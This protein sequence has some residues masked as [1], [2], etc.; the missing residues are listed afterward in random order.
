[1]GATLEVAADG[2]RAGPLAAYLPEGKSLDLKDGRIRVGLDAALGAGAAGGKKAR[3]IV[4]GFDYRD[5]PDGEPLASLSA[6]RVLASRIDPAGKVIAIDEVALEGLTARAETTAA[7]GVQALGLTVTPKKTASEASRP[8]PEAAAAPAPAGPATAAPAPAGTAPPAGPAVAAA[9]RKAPS[10]VPLV[11]LDKLHL[12]LASFKFRDLARG[13][14]PVVVSALLENKAR[15]ELLGDEPEGQPPV[16]LLATGSVAPI[17][18]SWSVAMRVAPFAA[19]PSL[20]V[21][22]AAQGI[23]G[24]GITSV[25]PALKEKLDGAELKDGRF[26]AHVEA[27][28]KVSRRGS[29]DI[30]LARGLGLDFLL[31][32]VEFKDGE[33]GPVLA[34]LDE[35]H[36]DLTK[37]DPKS[38]DVHVKAIEIVKP[39]G[40]VSRDKDGLHILGLLIKLPAAEPAVAGAPAPA[41]AAEPA[42]ASQPA[43]AAPA[44]V[45]ADAGKPAA[46]GPEVRIDKFTVTD[47]DFTVKDLVGEPPCI[48][49][50]VGL[51]IDVRG[52]STRALVEDRPVRFNMSVKSGKVPLPSTLKGGALGGALGDAVSVI[53]GTQVTGTKLEERTVFEELSMAGK[54]SVFPIPKGWVKL[55]ANAIDLGAFK[56][57]A[58][59]AG[60][61]LGGGVFDSAVAVRLVGDGSLDTSTR[62]IFTDLELS[63]PPDGPIFRYLH[64]PAPLSTVVFVLRDEN[65]SLKVPLDVALDPANISLA[66]LGAAA[67]ATFVKIVANAIAASPFRVAGTVVDVATLGQAEKA[68]K[69][70]EGDV[71]IDFSPGDAGVTAVQAAKLG[72]LLDRIRDGENIGLKLRHDLG[73]GDISRLGPRANPP[74]KDVE[75]FIE[76]MRRRRLT[77]TAER[78]VAVA[79][80]RAAVAARDPIAADAARER[81]SAADR[82]LGVLEDV[83]DRAHDLLRPGAERQA[84]RRTREACL[85]LAR[86]RLAAVRQALIDSGIKGME[87]RIQLANP[88]F[89]EV[90]G[91]APGKVS[92]E[93]ALK[94]ETAAV[95]EAK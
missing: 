75:S 40:L 78:G 42:P 5:G 29:L 91:T 63:E 48:V 23:H 85:G 83:L 39:K 43:P 67:S 93:A 13:G 73:G 7:G 14:E 81:L 16:D 55:G 50:L 38:G 37:F 44:A 53:G 47:I 76:G 46:P 87:A 90:E 3:L 2:L 80:A 28:L 30:D 89:V 22:V 79:R 57:P 9:P 26:A 56:G 88:R 17:I 49:P 52:L 65:G 77:L 66:S 62:L 51:D 68:E 15:V 19:E 86:E 4:S 94:V 45:A 95:A 92:V 71:S 41:P 69:E 54:L 61:S 34:G 59:S 8:A 72:A 11:T 27:L 24:E 58:A 31:K 33:A 12:E 21:D 32:G 25:L 6:F 64:L 84:G 74:R 1:M 70:S 36:V 35:L 18:G 10:P 82:E 60:V 20:Q